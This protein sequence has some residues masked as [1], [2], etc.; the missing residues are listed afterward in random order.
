MVISHLTIQL[1][2]NSS[3]EEE[4]EMRIIYYDQHVDGIDKVQLLQ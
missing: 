3:E 4:G 2:P 1:I